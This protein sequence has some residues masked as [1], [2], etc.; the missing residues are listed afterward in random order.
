VYVWCVVWCVCVYVNVCDVCLS[1]HLCVYMNVNAWCLHDMY[2]LCA[3]ISINVYVWCE[4]V[5]MQC[6][7]LV[8]AC[9]CVYVCG[10][11]VYV[12]YM[13]VFDVCL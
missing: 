4:C 8:N 2:G 3:C 6:V 10:I 7:V 5:E 9:E 1:V 13:H 11:C 12:M